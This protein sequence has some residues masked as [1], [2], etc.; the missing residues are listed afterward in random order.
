MGTSNLKSM[1]TI[2]SLRGFTLTEIMVAVAISSILLAGVV[3]IMS[4]SKRTYALQTELAELNDNARFIMDELSTVIREAGYSGCGGIYTNPFVNSIND[5]TDDIPTHFPPSDVL[6]INSLQQLNVDNPDALLDSQPI[7][8]KPNSLVPQQND[9]LFISDCGSPYPTH[10]YQ[11]STVT[12]GE[13]AWAKSSINVSETLQKIYTPPYDLLLR[14]Q[15]TYRVKF[16]ADTGFTL[17]KCFNDND[18]DC[19]NPLI[20]GVENLQIR[21]GIDTDAN[22]IPDW[23][24]N[25]PTGG[26]VISVRITLLMRTLNKRDLGGTVTNILHNRTFQLDSGLVEYSQGY[27]PYEDNTSQEQGYYHRLFTMTVLVRNSL[28]PI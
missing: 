20:E 10:S 14:N 25:F 11:V 9:N 15:L 26:N 2:K 3:S 21:Y 22:R 5:N 13:S 1:T 23:Y 7:S 8:L 24:N 16:Y 18:N 12:L 17:V 6:I 4:S 19:D 27:T 28:Y